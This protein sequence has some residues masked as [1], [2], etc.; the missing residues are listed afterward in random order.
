MRIDAELLLRA[1]LA[2]TAVAFLWTAVGFLAFA[3]YSLLVPLMSVAAAAALTGAII[4]LILSVGLLIYHL[5]T[6]EP[7][8]QAQPLPAMANGNLANASVAALAQLA[9]DH[10]L[11][12]VGCAAMLG[13]ADNMRETQHSR[14]NTRD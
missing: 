11:L 5:R 12:A 1:G 2:V 8:T 9:K 10:P 7:V 13:I 3:G 14:R 6:R 4:L